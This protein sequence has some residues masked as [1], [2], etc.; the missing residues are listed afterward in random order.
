MDDKFELSEVEMNYFVEQ[1]FKGRTNRIKVDDAETAIAGAKWTVSRLV[2]EHPDFAGIKAKAICVDGD[3][4]SV[5]WDSDTDIET[6]DV[7]A[8][9]ESLN[10]EEEE[11][12]PVQLN[13]PIKMELP[14]DDFEEPS[15]E[16]VEKA[17]EALINDLIAT[18]LATIDSITSA[19]ATIESD[20]IEGKEE[21]MKILDTIA[22]EKSIHL[23]MLTKV[24][25]LLG[26][27]SGDLMKQGIEKAEEVIGEETTEEPEEK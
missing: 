12:P 15:E 23:G 2:D 11:L 24:S 14:E 6:I 3:K 27:N 20:N 25:E 21:A 1:E 22:D 10:E 19:K 17:Y 7:T 9:D 8:T 13:E 26:S 16:V 18:E 4:E 5:L